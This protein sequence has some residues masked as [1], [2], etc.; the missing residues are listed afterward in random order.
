MTSSVW[1][2]IMAG[3]VGARFWPLSRLER[4][5]QFLSVFSAEPLLAETVHRLGGQLDAAHILVVTNALHVER[6]RELLP[7]LPPENVIGEPVG[8]NTAA[9]IALSAKL[10]RDREPDSRVIVLPA[11]HFVG[12]AE[13]FLCTLERALLACQGGHLVTLGIAPDRP[14]TGYGYIQHG[15]EE[16]SAGVHPVRTFA[17]KPNLATA[18][19]F[20][21]SG[22]F[23][24]NSGIF[25]WENDA[26]I[27]AL[28]TW[29]PETWE[30]IAA[31]QG[32]PGQSDFGAELAACYAGLR[33]VSIDVGVMEPAA[34]VAGKVRVIR[35]SFPWN[36]VGTWA[37]VHRMLE[38]DGEGNTTQGEALFVNSR[39]CHVQA[40]RRTVVL[41]GMQ[42]TIVVDTP[43]ALLVCPLSQDQE[44]RQVIQRLKEEG[45]H[46][47]L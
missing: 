29:L 17:E 7:E 3:G 12:D 14:E 26:L 33:P 18:L 25:V 30:A 6:T 10:I 28:E 34:R 36:D 11:D 9:C 38:G 43:D 4:P 45:L 22:D 47:L 35:A 42:D 40:D 32:A 27:A 8:R 24:W 13:E 23:L 16:L 2:V 41:L 44:I 15:E 37:E 19:R 5:K 46:E 39:N 1:A 31:L 20:L 21:R